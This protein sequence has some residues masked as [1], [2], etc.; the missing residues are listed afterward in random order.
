MNFTVN[1][2]GRFIDEDNLASRVFLA[3]SSIAS[4][5][6]FLRGSSRVPSPR[7]GG[8]IAR[9][10]PKICHQEHETKITA[11]YIFIRHSRFRT[12][13]ISLLYRLALDNCQQSSDSNKGS[14][15]CQ[16][17]SSLQLP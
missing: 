8:M 14:T 6:D 2:L 5:A 3:M 9:R 7:R 17:V 16:Q 13:K 4:H 10:T 1:G 12:L 15:D 11:F